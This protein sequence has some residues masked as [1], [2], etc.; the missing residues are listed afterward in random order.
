MKLKDWYNRELVEELAARFSRAFDNFPE[1]RFLSLATEGLEELEMMDRVRQIAGAMASTF[2]QPTAVAMRGLCECLGPALPAVGSDSATVSTGYALWPFGEYIGLTGL[3]D[4][5][6]SW[7]AMEE[8]TQRLT[9]EFAVRP[10]LTADLDRALEMFA[11]RVEHPSHHVRRW[12]SEGTRTR[13]PWGKAV[14]GLRQAVARRLA[15]LEKL[16]SDPSLY[17]RRSVANHLQDILKDD[18]EVG[19]EVVRRWFTSSEPE[20]DWVVRHACRGLLK[21]GHPEILA[22]YGLDQPIEV[23]KFGV[24][25]EEV[26]RGEGVALEVELCGPKSGCTVRLDFCLSGPTPSGGE[27]RKVFRWSEFELASGEIRS[28]QRS[29]PMVERSTRRLPLG[30]YRFS[31]LTNGCSSPEQT[32]RLVE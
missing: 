10:F 19:L 31:V 15:M 6:S 23:A 2:P 32:F 20:V 5:D 27:F 4:W 14:P 12:V 8:L 24:G 7:A 9:S 16:K 17:V 29:F 13:L 11:D 30:E 28:L 22:L 21:A 26:H 25:P 18:L 1:Q 3:E